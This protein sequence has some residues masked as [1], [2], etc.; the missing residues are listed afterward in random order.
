MSEVGKLRA[1][2]DARPA[3]QRHGEWECEYDAWDGVYDAV[4][5]FVG[6]RM[7]EEWS[8]DEVEA[9]LYAIARDNERQRIAEEIGDRHPDL[10]LP[11]AR[12]AL[13]HGERD[14]HWQLAHELGEGRADR[15]E[16]E[17]LLLLLARDEHEYVRRR[18]LA[19]LARLG[20]SSVEALALKAWSRPDHIRSGR[21]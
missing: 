7:P 20:S 14:D 11:L 17:R 21:G 4:L 9:V 1:W 5:A 12:A 8:A 18:A 13:A 3:D 6:Q 2:A 16:T 10:L 15:D 19:S